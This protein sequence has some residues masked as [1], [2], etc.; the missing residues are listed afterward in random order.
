M[1]STRQA[2]VSGIKAHDPFGMLLVGR[3][4]EGGSEYRY[5]FNGQEK[6]VDVYGNETVIDF[7]ARFYDS[8]LGRWL[9][10]D[11]LSGRHPEISPYATCNNNPILYIDSDGKDFYLNGNTEQAMDDIRGLVEKTTRDN[12]IFTEIQPGLFKVEFSLE[13]GVINNDA[14]AQLL[15]NL[16][17]ASEIYL[18]TVSNRTDYMKKNAKG[19]FEATWFDMTVDPT[20][21]GVKYG[22]A[23]GVAN[24]SETAREVDSDNYNASLDKKSSFVPVDQ[25]GLDVNGNVALAET[26]KWLHPDKSEYT[27]SEMA[28]HELWENYERTT[29]QLPYAYPADMNDKAV[30]KKAE[31]VGAHDM[32][33]R[34]Q[35]GKNSDR[36]S[37]SHTRDRNPA[38]AGRALYIE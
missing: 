28:F 8:R 26:G 24:W 12:I 30:E 21:K 29:N 19:E 17:S 31:W 16:T 2:K 27:R 3:N 14:G 4:W 11:P 9:S 38:V 7:G 34:A 22:E 25:F 32:S 13:G 15:L 18:Y 10:V 5:G 36:H 20:V 1:I 23:D 33:I 37:Y 6:E 35:T